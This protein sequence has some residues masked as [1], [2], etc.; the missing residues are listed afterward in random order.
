M[1]TSVSSEIINLRSKVELLETELAS[2]QS[3]VKTKEKLLQSLSSRISHCE[4][5]AGIGVDLSQPYSVPGYDTPYPPHGSVVRRIRG[6]SGDTKDTDSTLALGASS[7]L[8]YKPSLGSDASYEFEFENG[9]P[10]KRKRLPNG[11]G[12]GRKNQHKMCTFEGCMKM[13]HGPTYLFCL[14]HGGMLLMFLFLDSVLGGYRCQEPGC[15]RSAYSTK[16]CSRHGGGPRCQWEG[17]QKGAI[18]NSSFCRRHGGGSRCQHPNCPEG[19]RQGFNF[20]LNHGGF[21]PCAYPNCPGIAL[22]TASYCRQHNALFK[23]PPTKVE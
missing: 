2:L 23:A 5:L 17:C 6:D 16:F 1:S 15:T 14:R 18:S 13:A 21:N 20:C 7:F 9:S 4:S 22:L 8:S 10:V 3:A 11:Q 19:A 12:T